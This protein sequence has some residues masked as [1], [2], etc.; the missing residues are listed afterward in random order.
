[1]GMTDGRGKER[2]DLETGTT[3][4]EYGEGGNTTT[5]T[6]FLT[7]AY[8]ISFSD[9]LLIFLLFLLF[10]ILL[11]KVYQYAFKKDKTKK[12]N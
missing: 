5:T 3:T 4:K 7:T 8:A 10:L 12:K 1:M 11:R 9:F 2:M 6:S